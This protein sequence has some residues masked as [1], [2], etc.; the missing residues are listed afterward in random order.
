[1]TYYSEDELIE[2]PTI[3][4]FQSLGY[5][6]KYCYNETFGDNGTLGR[7]TP[8][9]VVI[10]ERLKEAL[11]KL[12]HS[13]TPETIALAIEELTRDRR[14]MNPA[15]VNREI[16]RMLRDGVKVSMRN[17][18]GSEEV[19][20]IKVIDFKNHGNNDFLLTSQLWVTGEMY[21]RRADLVGFVNGLPLIFIELKAVHKKLENAFKDNLT[22]Y[23]DTI[24]QLFWYNAFIIISNGAES[25]IG[26]ISADYEHFSEWKKIN[27]EGE[28]GIVS[29]ETIIKGTC[30]KIKF[31]DLLENFVLYQD[32]GGA[33]IKVIAKN[34]QYLG[35]NNA[36]ESF[37]KIKEQ[38][39]RLGVFWHT[40][41]SGKSFSMIFFSQKI[42]RK[43][44]GNYT[45]LIVTDRKEL[46]NQIYKNFANCG[47]VTEQEVHAE[48]GKHLEQLLKENHRNIFTLIHKFGDINE[49]VS[50]RSDIIVITDEAHRS[51][52]DLL[53]MNMRK[54]LP[55]AA[56]IAF[57]GTPL[58]VGE[59]LTKKTFGD[60][61][62]I[63]NFKQSVDD[64]ATV[65]L[66]YENRIPEVQLKNEDLND[67][68]QKIIEEAMLDDEQEEKLQR[69]FA[70]QYHIIT[71]DDRLNKI[72]EDIVGH[73]ANRGYQGKAMVVSIDKPTAVKM[74]D[75]VQK[76]WGK[77]IEELKTKANG[78]K[79]G[80]E[81][82]EK[83]IRYME[84][85]DMA[86]VVSSEQNEIEK[87]RKLKLDIKKHRERMVKEDLAEKFK[88][89]DNPFR[90]V[91][92]CAMW[93]TG[94]DVQSLSTIYLDKPMKN[95]T[96][97]Q[98]IA[99]ANRVF[100]NKTNGLIVDYIGIFRELQKALA[101]YG[102]G[103]GGGIR[104]GDTPIKPKDEL[105]KELEQALADTEQFLK[106]RGID[107]EKII[108]ANKLEKIKLLVDAVDAILINDESKNRYLFLAGVVK[109]FFKAI[110]P[111]TKANK[112]YERC[113]LLNAIAE[114]IRSMT[115][116]TDISVVTGKIEKILD[117][118][119][120]AEGYVIEQLYEDDGE[121]Y[122]I[123]LSKIDLE[124]LRKKF[125]KEHKHI[126]VEI[127]KWKIN[128]K[129][130]KMV[131]LNKTRIDF[132]EKFQS[133]LDEY[134]SGAV[135]IESFFDEL[136]EFAQNLNEE[137][138]RGIAESLSEEE[139]AVFDLLK[140]P[141]INKK[142][143]QQVKSACKEL[144]EKL[145]EEKLVLDWRKK[146]Q[147]R[148]QVL[149]TIETVLDNMLPESYSK[150]IFGKI[151]TST[152][153]HIYDSYYGAGKSIYDLHI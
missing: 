111:D 126:Q 51:Q 114:K 140:K 151:C 79:S 107:S 113:A 68:L 52:Y 28:E 40:Q 152:Y 117:D 136:L 34:H 77:Y 147:T 30:N 70:R 142:E 64:N 32:T 85:T 100:R 112:F 45:F 141:D 16:Y 132:L 6:Y 25:R 43:F 65:P 19:E 118:S 15:H 115:E 89:P 62:S 55:N 1:M 53:A 58:M 138:K 42:L 54:A 31:I 57:T 44:E 72:A 80:R 144:L 9:E 8:S 5:D 139:L 29:L 63:Y 61:I 71:R 4:L 22:D 10:V 122:R 81:L 98:T 121:P 37:G 153:Q 84:E 35:V 105:I 128:S 103:A 110:L 59:E 48:S 17:A 74:Y 88:D 124:A 14:A 27:S 18:D 39:G 127:L 50:D 47:A 78:M 91:F 109:K 137:D 23:K 69:E 76:Y 24:P 145:K 86:V 49:K 120:E 149:F 38:E 7:D 26:S 67:D 123:D 20:I 75:K 93:M 21:K 116:E 104:T 148:A 143:S 33:L 73:F 96:L 56:F 92:V 99:R 125:A 150:D 94:F 46:D 11:V 131:R 12:N 130:T 97:M 87:F 135:N 95:H 3:E 102:S 106:E 108:K 36:I 134:N 146:Q 90:I 2:Q 66:Y 119:I 60:Y 133:L 13:A 82:I 83:K 129:L 101:I 41:G